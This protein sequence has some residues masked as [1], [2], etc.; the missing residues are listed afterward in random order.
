MNQKLKGVPETMLITLWAKA[1]EN[2]QPKPIVKDP[3]ALEI[4]EKIDY[5]FSKFEKGWLSQ[6]GVVIRTELFDNAAKAFISKNP[7]AVIINIGCGLDT[8]FIK[9]DNNKIRW[10][11]LDLPE[12]I[13]IKKNFFKETDRYKMIAKSVF[14]YSWIDEIN[15]LKEPVLIIA[16]GLLM[17]FTEEE[18]KGI[19]NKLV[20]AFPEAEM[21]LE[22]ITPTIVKNSKR[23]DTVSKLGVEFKWGIN[24]GKDI[25][26]INPNIQFIQEFNYFDYHKDR[27]RFVKWFALIPAFKNRFNGRLLHVKFKN[28]KK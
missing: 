24:T 1:V 28:K 13:I 15:I 2:K 7:N 12:S 6:A 22:M 17:Y 20:S 27:W 8:R 5:D 21:L 18:V 11:D 3:K 10:Y 9:I 23:H 25:E 4:M 16:E 14:D 26:K 19:M